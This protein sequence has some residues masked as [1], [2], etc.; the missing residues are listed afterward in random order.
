LGMNNKPAVLR[1]YDRF[2]IFFFSI[3]FPGNRAD[4]D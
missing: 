2:A 3:A 4:A 1:F